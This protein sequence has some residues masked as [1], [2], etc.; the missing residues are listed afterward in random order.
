MVFSPFSK[1]KNKITD[2]LF[3]KIT[4]STGDSPEENQDLLELIEELDQD[5]GDDFLYPIK[6]SLPYLTFFQTELLFQA[7]SQKYGH[8]QVEEVA[9]AHYEGRDVVTDGEAFVSPLILEGNYQ[10][11]LWPLIQ[12][13][14]TSSEFESYSYQEKREYFENQVYP[15]YRRSLN[16]SDATLPLFPAEGEQLEVARTSLK[17]DDVI[18]EKTS[19]EGQSSPKRFYLLSAILGL[20]AVAG[21]G[22]SVLTVSQLGKVKQELQTVRQEVKVLQSFKTIENQVDVFSRYFLPTYYSGDKEALRQF[23]SDGNAKYTV[24]ESGL[25]RSV[26]LESLLFEPNTEEYTVTYVLSVKKEE[27]T[28]NIRLSFSIKEMKNSKY[29]FVVTTEPKESEYVK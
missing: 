24:P 2:D 4:W 9:L 15:V 16:I 6:Q 18:K 22:I 26:I 7:L 3:V 20:L 12:S 19:S 21:L 23:L 25:L 1:S 13:I 8:F 28:A 11:I 17:K 14:L 27:D 10:T 29:G 5:H